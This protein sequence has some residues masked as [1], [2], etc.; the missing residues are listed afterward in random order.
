MYIYTCVCCMNIYAGL[1]G[2]AL[3]CK[4]YETRLTDNYRI[5]YSLLTD[6]P[7]HYS[8]IM[9]CN[10]APPP[11]TSPPPTVDSGGYTVTAA[12]PGRT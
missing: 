6:F 7:D 10:S 12:P 1:E 4:I 8:W 11:R 9:D 5:Y 2:V 3:Y